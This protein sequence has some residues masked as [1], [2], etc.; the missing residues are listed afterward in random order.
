MAEIALLSETKTCQQNRQLFK[1]QNT[2]AEVVCSVYQ[3]PTADRQTACGLQAVRFGQ[4]SKL[5]LQYQTRIFHP[6]ENLI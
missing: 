6:A 2:E 5:L 1:I 3:T 4:M